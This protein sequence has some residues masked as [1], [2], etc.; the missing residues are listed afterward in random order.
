MLLLTVHSEV[1]YKQAW[2]YDECH[3][4]ADQRAYDDCTIVL[5]GDESTMTLTYHCAVWDAHREMW[6]LDEDAVVHYRWL[7]TGPQQIDNPTM[8]GCPVTL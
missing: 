3:A 8:I 1:N 2:A 4:I 6:V 5:N 7:D